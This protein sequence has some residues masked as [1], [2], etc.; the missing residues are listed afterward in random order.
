MI[1]SDAELGADMLR[2]RP[3]MEALWNV[4]GLS[5]ALADNPDLAKAL[6]KTPALVQ[7]S[8][9]NQQVTPA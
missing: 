3:L 8:L 6:V 1:L 9:N 7:F 2:Q 5:E 4:P